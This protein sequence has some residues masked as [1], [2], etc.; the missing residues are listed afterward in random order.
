MTTE[1]ALLPL[2]RVAGFV[3]LWGVCDGELERGWALYEGTDS[4]SRCGRLAVGRVEQTV[5]DT[6]ALNFARG[7]KVCSD[8]LEGKCQLGK[9]LDDK[10]ASSR[11]LDNAEWETVCLCFPV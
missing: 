11:R 9:G 10:H 2:L 8:Q 1:P 6:V 4:N 5:E 3:L 7:V